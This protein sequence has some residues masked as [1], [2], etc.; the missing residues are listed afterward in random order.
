M[1]SLK[2]S[3][4]EWKQRV[5][6]RAR[7]NEPPLETF[8]SGMETPRAVRGGASV[9]SALK[10]SLVEWKHLTPSILL[11]PPELLE[12]FLSGMETRARLRPLWGIAGPL[13]PSLV[14]WKLPV[15][16]DKL[17]LYTP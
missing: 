9:D 3:L 1:Q 13:K 6:C 14:E 2:P 7:H 12:T 8:L 11:L 15:G 4:V 5:C 17:G 16:R 10:P